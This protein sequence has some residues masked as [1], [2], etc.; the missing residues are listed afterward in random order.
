MRVVVEGEAGGAW[1]LV[2]R[3]GGWV[4]TTAPGL[5][6]AATVTLPQEVAWKVWTKRRPV[7]EKLRAFPG[8]NI[9]GDADLGRL[10]V[11]MVSVMA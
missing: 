6:A 11:G 1:W 7:D 5:Q 10:V 3:H 8:I 9:Q 4:Q 2:R